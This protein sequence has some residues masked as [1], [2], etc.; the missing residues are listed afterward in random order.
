MKVQNYERTETPL[1]ERVRYFV[2]VMT[3]CAVAF[4]ILVALIIT[5]DQVVYGDRLPSFTGNPDY[6]SDRAFCLEIRPV[7]E[8]RACLGEYGW[9]DKPAVFH[10]GD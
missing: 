8:L 7:E 10:L 4:F 5:I 9:F 1:N 2:D 3:W 6:S